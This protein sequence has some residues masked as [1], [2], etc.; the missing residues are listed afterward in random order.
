MHTPS[1]FFAEKVVDLAA[2]ERSSDGLVLDQLIA[3]YPALA[4]STAESSAVHNPAIRGSSPPS[5]LHLQLQ[6]HSIPSPVTIAAAAAA[7]TDRLLPVTPFSIH[8]LNI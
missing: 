6:L 3:A 5:C 7:A 8:E 4:R 2:R 1:T